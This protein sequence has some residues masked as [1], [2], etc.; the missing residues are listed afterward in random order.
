MGVIE[1]R[2]QSR[3]KN[4]FRPNS[5]AAHSHVFSLIELIWVMVIIMIIA[6]MSMGIASSISK[7]GGADGG[8]RML[9][10][11]LFLCRDYAIMNRRKV[12]LLLPTVDDLSG[13]SMIQKSYGGIAMRACLLKP[14]A[15]NEFES[16]IGDKWQV[17]PQLVLIDLPVA[18]DPAAKN[19]TKVTNVFIDLEGSYSASE[20]TTDINVIN[21]VMAIIFRPNGSLE[22]ASDVTGL[23][24]T[25]GVEAIHEIEV[26]W[27]TGKARFVKN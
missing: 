17:I 15:G 21:G 3:M 20:I 18:P 25:D 27:L 10:R 14:G 6:G 12:A 7:A 8:A 26:N 5:R 1:D 2:E 11:Q 4:H 13:D 24:I 16:F 9:S 23:Q 19:L 22:T